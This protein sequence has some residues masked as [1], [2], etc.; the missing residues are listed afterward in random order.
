MGFDRI[1]GLSLTGLLI[2]ADISDSLSIPEYYPYLASRLFV[3]FPSLTTIV[4]E[5][6]SD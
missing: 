2:T 4:P 1:P 6:L 3:F 5:V